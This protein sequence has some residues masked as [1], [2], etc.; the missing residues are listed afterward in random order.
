MTSAI[1]FDVDDTLYLERDYV[2]SGFEAVCQHVEKCYAIK[3]FAEIAWQLFERGHRGRIFDET[4]A[5]VTDEPDRVPIDALVEVYRTHRPTIE[6]LPDAR[7]TLLGLDE[8]DVRVAVIT[9]GPAASQHAKVSALGLRGL[10]EVVVVTS[11]LG[12]GYGK[13]HEAAFQIVEE[14]LGL[15]GA[16]LTYVADNPAKDFI[17]PRQRGW[18]SIR[19]RRSAGLHYSV[20]SGPDVDIESNELT[21]S[22]LGVGRPDM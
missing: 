11:D 16:E 3:G 4:L 22:L 6:L 9:D 2:R 19:I 13:P 7:A 17:A 10:S 14:T 20:D 21:M 5:A 12:P 18:R 15:P 1:V 8:R